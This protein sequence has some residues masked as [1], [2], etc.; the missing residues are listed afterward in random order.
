M[1]K[2]PKILDLFGWIVKCPAHRGSYYVKGDSFGK[3]RD[4]YEATVAINVDHPV[5]GKVKDCLNCPALRTN[6]DWDKD[7]FIICNIA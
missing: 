1:K 7:R 5:L 6:K 2:I 4:F 3:R